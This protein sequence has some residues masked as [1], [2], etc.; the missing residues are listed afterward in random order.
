MTELGQHQKGRPTSK[1]GL[2]EE[3][4]V[5]TTRQPAQELKTIGRSQSPMKNTN[6]SLTSRVKGFEMIDCLKE[7]KPDSKKPPIAISIDRT[8]LQ[9]NKEQRMHTAESENIEPSSKKQSDF[10][11]KQVLQSPVQ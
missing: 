9:L 6:L 7:P 8:A 11:N 4:R 1:A 2:F 10:M 5:K 3:N